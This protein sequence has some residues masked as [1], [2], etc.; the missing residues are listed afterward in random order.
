M[1]LWAES[2]GFSRIN[3]NSGVIFEAADLQSVVD[4]AKIIGWA[5]EGMVVN[6][7][8]FYSFYFVAVDWLFSRYSVISTMSDFKLLMSEFEVVETLDYE[9]SA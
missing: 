4:D 7:F 9:L 6:L 5:N 2:E 1:F 3:L 8:L